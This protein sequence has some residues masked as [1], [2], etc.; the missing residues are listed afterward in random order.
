LL[1]AASGEARPRRRPP[2]SWAARDPTRR[3]FRGPT[4]EAGAS[5][6]ES[7]CWKGRAS[8]TTS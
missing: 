4:A 1:A 6:L 2:S 7:G 5:R 8:P 3:R